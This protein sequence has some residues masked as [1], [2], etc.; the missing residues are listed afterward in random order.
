MST[1]SVVNHRVVAHS[2]LLVV[3]REPLKASDAL[4]EKEKAVSLVVVDA[5]GRGLAA[6]QLVRLKALMEEA[7]NRFD[8]IVQK[9]HATHTEACKQRSA[10]I[11]PLDEAYLIIGSK[12]CA[13]D[14]AERRRVEAEDAR[15]LREAN[16]R[17]LEAREADIVEAE[18][19]GASTVEVAALCEMP[20]V[21]APVLVARR[22][23]GGPVSSRVA[24]KALVTNKLALVQH[25]AKNPTYLH[26]LDP[27][28]SGLNKLASAL[29]LAMQ[30]PGVEL[31]QQASVTT[32]IAQR[33]TR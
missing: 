20:V 6:S 21:A 32:R 16:A 8:P 33:G 10:V 2:G 31:V 26:L 12:V 7:R 30:I 9:A 4:T 23:I 1:Q 19:S 22:S 14:L 5:E 27:N 24:Y 25:I 11:Q 18:A 3:E 28:E 17:A 15:L 13:F 29:G